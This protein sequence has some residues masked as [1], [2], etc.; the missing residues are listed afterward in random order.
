MLT[1]AE[2]LRKITFEEREYFFQLPLQLVRARK[3]KQLERMFTD[4]EFIEAKCIAGKLF[5]L[6]RDYDLVMGTYRLPAV[7]QVRKAIALVLSSLSERPALA[8]QTIYNQ[9]IW[10]KHIEAPLQAR[11]QTARTLLDQKYFWISAEAPLPGSQAHGTTSVLFE[12]HSSIQSFSPASMA[13]GIASVYGNIEVRN[14]PDGEMLNKQSLNTPRIA[15]IALFDDPAY[16]AHIDLDGVIRSNKGYASLMGRRDERLLAYHSQRGIIAMRSDNALVAW[17]PDQD[18]TEVIVTDLTAPL[19]VLKISMDGRSLLYVTGFKNQKIGLALWAG[20]HWISKPLSYAGPP[21]ADADLNSESTRVLLASMERRLCILDAQT[22]ELQHDLAYE[23]R[24]DALL[25]GAPVK[26]AFGMADSFGSAFV[27]TRA[28]HIACWNWQRD[29]L[30]RLDDYHTVHQLANLIEFRV[31]HLTGELFF[32][33]ETYAKVISKD[34]YYKRIA[35]HTGAVSSCCFTFSGQVVSASETDQVIRWYSADGLKPLAQQVRDHWEPTMISRDAETDNVIVGSR[36]GRLWRQRPYSEAL[37]VEIFMAFA[38]PVVSFFSVDDDSV[39]AAAQSGRVLRI[40]L[41][42]DK[43]DRLWHGKGTQRQRKILP[44]RQHGLYWSFYEDE[45]AE[46]NKLVLS[47]VTD[48]N[49]E[50]VILTSDSISDAIVSRDGL[51]ICTAGRSVQILRQIKGKW[52]VIYHRNTSVDRVAFL[53]E[54]EDLIAVGLNKGSWLEVWNITDGLPT[55]AAIDLRDI[56]SC[57]SAMGDWIVAGF[58][59]GALMVVRLCRGRYA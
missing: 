51:T 16:I 34:G 25:R 53:G 44:A 23:L 6:L 24:D 40:H 21:I 10:F 48:V 45:G 2:N 36:S 33:T 31:L 41:L 26:C 38:E 49:K 22:G 28:G 27:A 59:S 58:R 15:A 8:L 17:Q 13:I 20:D 11:L 1:L 18:H 9:L 56:L 55:V 37:E 7:S 29:Q 47:L 35:G 32:T 50:K 14:M 42:T 5:E 12:T 46:Q 4:L 57:L 52:S 43:V 54:K 39:I 30:K 3:R 19:V